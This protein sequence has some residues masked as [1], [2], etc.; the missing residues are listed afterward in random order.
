M[1]INLKKT[2]NITIALKTL[3]FEPFLT[4]ITRVSKNLTLFF[5]FFQYHKRK[6][7]LIIMVSTCPKDK[8]LLIGYKLTTV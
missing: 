2:A 5:D 8:K 1:K 3:L 4:Q 6:Y 7:I